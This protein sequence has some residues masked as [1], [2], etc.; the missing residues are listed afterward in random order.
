MRAI[1]VLINVNK[2]KNELPIISDNIGIIENLQDVTN[3]KYTTEEGHISCEDTYNG[4]IDII[5]IQGKT[6]ISNEGSTVNKLKSVSEDANTLE[7]ISK[8][9]NETKQHKKQISY[10]NDEGQLAPITILRQWDSIYKKDGKIYYEIGSEQTSYTSGDESKPDCITDMTNTVKKLA[11]PKIYEC[12]NLNLDSYPNQTIVLCNSGVVKPIIEFEITSHINNTVNIMKDRI[13]YLEEKAP[14][15]SL[16]NVTLNSCATLE[17]KDCTLNK[18]ELRK[19]FLASKGECI[20]ATT[21]GTESSICTGI[22]KGLNHGKYAI[23]VRLA[24]GTL[25][26][27]SV[28]KII[29][30]AKGKTT[31][32]TLATKI[33]DG[34]IFTTADSFVQVYFTV[35]FKGVETEELELEMDL[36]THT[37][38]S[39]N[40]VSFDYAYA[41][42]IMPSVYI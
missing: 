36:L 15:A 1:D 28:I 31:N 18:G 12:I 16:S 6:I 5:K 9:S 19:T 26:S 38:S 4:Q 17:A 22:F 21:N 20:S 41:N 25:T 24:I 37:G 2:A 33:V 35:D 42:L 11:I 7:I 3:T 40:V 32:T 29:L 30:K 14:V 13:K 10:Y 23:S 39:N 34:S 8:N 27:A